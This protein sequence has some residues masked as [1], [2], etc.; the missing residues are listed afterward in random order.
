MSKIVAV[1]VGTNLDKLL[2]HFWLLFA[3]YALIIAE[4][5]FGVNRFMPQKN[6]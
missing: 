6:P 3:V 2:D 5:Q 1:S 4:W